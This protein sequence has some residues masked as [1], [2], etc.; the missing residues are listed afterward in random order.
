MW[1]GIFLVLFEDAITIPYRKSFQLFQC[2]HHIWITITKKIFLY[3]YFLLVQQTWKIKYNTMFTQF[4][5][6][7][8]PTAKTFPSS[9]CKETGRPVGWSRCHNPWTPI[10]RVLCH[11]HQMTNCGSITMVWNENCCSY[12]FQNLL[13]FYFICVTRIP[14]ENVLPV[15]VYETPI[16]SELFFISGTRVLQNN[17]GGE[18]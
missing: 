5:C 8:I 2:H 4:T 7:R 18:W 6:L 13:S 11:K 9:D 15:S 3:N 12:Y 14:A 16:L 1:D 17:N 10:F